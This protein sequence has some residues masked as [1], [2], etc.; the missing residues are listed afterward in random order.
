ME[1]YVNFTFLSEKFLKDKQPPKSIRFWSLC[2]LIFL[3]I[4]DKI[5]TYPMKFEYV[6]KIRLNLPFCLRSTHTA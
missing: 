6:N 5:S 2:M 4:S 3:W 1:K